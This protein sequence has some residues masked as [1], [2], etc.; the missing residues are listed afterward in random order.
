M[1]E[2]WEQ[3]MRRFDSGDEDVRFP[4][5]VL[6]GSCLSDC[7]TADRDGRWAVEPLDNGMQR[8]YRDA[9]DHLGALLRCCDRALV[10]GFGDFRH[11][12][13]P[14]AFDKHTEFVT[15]LF[16]RAGLPVWDSMEHLRSIASYRTR[17]DPKWN[18]PDWF[19]HY[20]GTDGYALPKLYE[21]TL[22]RVLKW[23]G[24]NQPGFD[25]RVMDAYFDVVEARRKATVAET[26]AAAAP[27][28]SARS[29]AQEHHQLEAALVAE[30]AVPAEPVVESGPISITSSDD[31]DAGSTG[32]SDSE[33]QPPVAAQRLEAACGAD[34]PS[35]A[36]AV[37]GA[38][39]SARPSTGEEKGVQIDLG[40][41]LVAGRLTCQMGVDRVNIAPR[42]RQCKKVGTDPTGAIEVRPA[43]DADPSGSGTAGESKAHKVRRLTSHHCLEVIKYVPEDALRR[44]TV[45]LLTRAPAS[46]RRISGTMPRTRPR[47]PAVLWARIG[48]NGSTCTRTPPGR[49]TRLRRIPRPPPR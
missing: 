10:M 9:V 4:V 46:S 1:T 29:P 42:K 20:Q 16:R 21:R 19:H 34:A 5:T 32:S 17:I 48:P 49:A 14:P 35:G 38:V 15:E 47:S 44:A 39:A 28:G 2:R 7:C 13:L 6:V 27:N 31:G 43:G 26:G 22:I 37:V 11:W 41:E 23:L 24:V 36:K 3:K 33:V 30:G 8:Y 12:Q 25:A 18:E 45:P 40:R